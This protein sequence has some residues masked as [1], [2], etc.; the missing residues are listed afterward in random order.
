MEALKRIEANTIEKLPPRK[1]NGD[2]NFNIN[3]YVA[4]REGRV[5]RAWPCTPRTTDERAGPAKPAGDVRFAGLRREGA[6]LGLRSRACCPGRR[7]IESGR[8]PL[9][10]S[11]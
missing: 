8:R 6:S 4:Q 1:K 5:R 10:S 2:P 3:F 9:F 11:G 7:R